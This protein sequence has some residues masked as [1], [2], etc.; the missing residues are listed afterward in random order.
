MNK[1]QNIFFLFE[2][3][4]QNRRAKWRK[5]EK[6]PNSKDIK[7]Q[8]TD[9]DDD[10]DYISS[11]CDEEEILDASEVTSNHKESSKTINS[12]ESN[13][14]E[15]TAHNDGDL[16]KIKQNE[17]NGP[18][19]TYNNETS[20]SNHSEN[21][22]NGNKKIQMFHSI[23]SLLHHPSGGINSPGKGETV[24]N[25]LEMLHKYSMQQHMAEL[26]RGLLYANKNMNMSSRSSSDSAKENSN[27]PS[28]DVKS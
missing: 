6:N 9:D 5:T 4:F 28:P 23:N 13:L 12:S 21:G 7:N 27:G 20:S 10:E 14:N 26:N 18:H 17:K 2:V 3:W 1:F 16:I 22:E 15:S 24:R 25:E 8:S 19:K 11:V